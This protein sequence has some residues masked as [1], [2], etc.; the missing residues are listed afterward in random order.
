MT[1]QD[2]W[3]YRELDGEPTPGVGGLD[4]IFVGEWLHV[5]RMAENEWWGRIESARVYV[6]L[7]AAG[8]VAEL[9]VDHDAYPEHAAK[10]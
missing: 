1:K 3:S 7:D 8:R 2:E 4:E 5:E 9:Q 10:K 6:V